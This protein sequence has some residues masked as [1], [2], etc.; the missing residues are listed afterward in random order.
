M[1]ISFDPRAPIGSPNAASVVK[2]V[3]DQS[4]EVDVLAA[5]DSAVVVVDLWAQWCGPCKTLGP[6]LESAIAARAPRVRL[7]KIDVDANPMA[8]A[9]FQVQSIP[10]VFAI[11]NRKVADNFVGAQT[12]DFIDKW[13]DQLLPEESSSVSA[14]QS[15]RALGDVAA[16]R[17]LLSAEP[18][19][20]EAIVGLADVLI[21]AGQFEEVEALLAKVPETTEVRTLRARLHHGVSGDGAL[22][23]AAVMQKLDVLLQ[24]VKVDDAARTAYVEL[25]DLL[26]A[27]NPST[28][29]Y[30]KRLTSALF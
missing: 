7:A 11:S 19:N 27:E 14:A 1:V 8:S 22:D 23:E 28:A 3:T 25:L 13:L 26:G 6:M 15:A 17:T 4:F 10:A 9:S 2:D 18:A 21:N 24:S 30:R 20:V 12:K 29:V 16:L 5:S